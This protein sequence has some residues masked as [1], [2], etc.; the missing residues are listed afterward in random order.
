MVTQLHRID[1]AVAKGIADTSSAQ[2][3]IPVGLQIF[4]AA[5]LGIGTLTLKESVR[6]LTQKGRYEEA[7][8]SL[9]WIRASDDQDVVWEMEEIRTGVE[10]AAHARE[11]FLLKGPAALRFTL[12]VFD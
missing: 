6:W 1:Y 5:L 10:L 9:K 7:W 11:G 8:E 3:Q 2:W 4:F 12:L